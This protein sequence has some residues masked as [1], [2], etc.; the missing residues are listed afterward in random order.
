MATHVK[1]KL[2]RKLKAVFIRAK[3]HRWFAPINGMLM[4]LC[5]LTKLSQ[6]CAQHNRP[7]FNDFS[8]RGFRSEKRHTLYEH[9]FETMH[10]D[11]EISYLEFGVG[12]G[13]SLRWWLEHNRHPSSRFVGFD[14]FTGLPEDWGGILKRGTF[15]TGGSLPT[16]DD[17]RCRLEA[18]LFQ[19]TLDNFLKTFHSARVTVVHLD[20]D[21]YSSTLFV[22][23]RLSPFL[24][25]GD[26][27]LFDEFS[28]PLDEFKAFTD[29]VSAY[30]FKY[31]VLGA[32]NNY[33]QIAIVVE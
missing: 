20:A 6:W 26:I 27:L 9:I 3:L 5:Y 29:F 8:D 10:L 4:Q 22:L 18:G 17:P 30:H 28:V 23:T 1:I 31:R 25:K 13:H 15:T 11:E 33:L 16:V 21:L 19:H 14:T 2:R 32:V 24:K 12:H 7:S